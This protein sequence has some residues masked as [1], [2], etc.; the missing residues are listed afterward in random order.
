M[1]TEWVFMV[2]GRA[3]EPSSKPYLDVQKN[4]ISC[5]CSGIIDAL[6]TSLRD[7]ALR[8]SG[9]INPSQNIYKRNDR[10]AFSAYAQEGMQVDQRRAF[11]IQK[12]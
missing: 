4:R 3:L 5:H 2:L 10:N 7:V 12:T 8:V 1:D 9:W 6:T 11:L